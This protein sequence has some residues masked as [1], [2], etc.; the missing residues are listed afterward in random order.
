MRVCIDDKWYV[1]GPIQASTIM[2]AGSI[3]YHEAGK[4]EV[5]AKYH[6]LT[7]SLQTKGPSFT[8]VIFRHKDNLYELGRSS[9][10]FANKDTIPISTI[11]LFPTVIPEKTPE[12]RSFK[13]K[14]TLY[15][16]CAEVTK[17]LPPYAKGYKDATTNEEMINALDDTGI[18][19]FVFW[20]REFFNGDVE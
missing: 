9:H 2:E 3:F 1:L 15:N 8:A 6:V 19:C 20:W 14:Q 16:I 18:K 7:G 4:D 17:E 11:T 12:S 5:Y 13:S 10:L